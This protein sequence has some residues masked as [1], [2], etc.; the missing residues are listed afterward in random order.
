MSLDTYKSN[1]KIND[2]TC[3]LSMVTNIPELQKNIIRNRIRND[4]ENGEYFF[5]KI[6][7]NMSYEKAYNDYM[8]KLL[9]E[10]IVDSTTMFFANQL[11]RIN[12]AII[13]S[14]EGEF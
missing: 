1:G 8:N 10:N 11:I 13:L 7:K 5:L 14:I 12:N 9:K 2:G 3:V 4:I 6:H